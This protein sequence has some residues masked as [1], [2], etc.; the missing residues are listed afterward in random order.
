MSP[1]HILF[2]IEYATLESEAGMVISK[3]SRYFCNNSVRCASDVNPPNSKEVPIVLNPFPIRAMPQAKSGL[4]FFLGL[5]LLQLLPVI[6]QSNSCR[7]R[8]PFSGFGKCAIYPDN[9]IEIAGSVR[10][11]IDAK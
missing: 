6:G 5:Q 2:D 10:N 9:C 7:L 8:S 3:K 11:A 1:S 4:L